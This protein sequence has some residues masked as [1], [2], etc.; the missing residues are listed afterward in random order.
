MVVADSV[1][2]VP[3]GV[4]ITWYGHGTWGFDSPEGVRIILDPWL[5][6]NPSCP[7]SMQEPEVDII[8]VTHGHF[9]HVASVPALAARFPDAPVLAKPELAGHLSS[10]APNTIGFNTGGTVEVRGIR[11]TMTQAFHSSSVQDSEGR[12][13]YAGEPA[14]YVI[15]FE[16]DYRVYAAGDTSVFGDMA[17]IGELYHPDLAILPIG[18][19]FTMGP[20]EAAKAVELLGVQ[21]VIGGH[22]GTFP[23]LTG[24]PQQLRA[25]LAKRTLAD[26]T[27]HELGPG[28]ALA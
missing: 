15:T 26:V 8:L 3:Q 12:R 13:S 21:D 11:F 5:D 14:G 10:S 16:N 17:L 6:G 28:E 24:T 18:D 4:P 1:L 19:L 25:E 2:T 20:Y 7:V 27:V 22:W 9:D 23:E